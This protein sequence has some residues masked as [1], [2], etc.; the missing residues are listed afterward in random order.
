M[1]DII[2]NTH[3]LVLKGVSPQMIHE[4]F[5]TKTKDE[6]KACLGAEEQEYERF[7]SMH[8]KGME[9]ESFSML[10][11]LLIEKTSNLPIGRCGF[12]TW[13]RRHKRAEL[14][15]LLT[16]DIYKRKGLMTEALAPVLRYAFEQMDIHR[17]EALVAN[18]N[19]PSLSLLKRY[20]FSFEG[21]RREDYVVDGKSENSDCYSLLKHE[22]Q[23]REQQ[24][25]VRTDIANETA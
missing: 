6:I 16:D 15:Y 10:F 7:K 13:N 17:I 5:L 24:A 21:T 11:F 2:I 9:T 20:G 3:R 12:H 14:F 8:E 1:T 22:W 19:T 23:A 4:L 25:A 18:W